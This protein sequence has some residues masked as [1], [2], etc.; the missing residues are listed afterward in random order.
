MLRERTK[1]GLESARKQG[2]IGG[3]RPKLRPRWAGI[4]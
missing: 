2:R 3:R 1:A 4:G